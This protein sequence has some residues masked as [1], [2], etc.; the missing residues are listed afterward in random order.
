MTQYRVKY[1]QY[2]NKESK[3]VNDKFPS[4]EIKWLYSCRVDDYL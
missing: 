3:T 1:L 4:L 2:G